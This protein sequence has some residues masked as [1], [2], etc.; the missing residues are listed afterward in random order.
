MPANIII[1]LIS[2]LIALALYSIGTWGAYRSRGTKK[3]DIGLI[4]AGFGFDVI[5]TAM[6]AI[7]AG[8]L[9]KDLHT[10]L[11]LTAM[12]GMLFSAIMGPWSKGKMAGVISRWVLAPWTLWVVVFIWGMVE[13]GSVRLMH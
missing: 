8:G 7:Q 12:A 2:L 5:A 10:I 13:R 6:M 9:Q 1:G 4:W 11:A 3:R